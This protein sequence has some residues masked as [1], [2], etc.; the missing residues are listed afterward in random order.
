MSNLQTGSSLVFIRVPRDPSFHSIKAVSGPPI[1]ESLWSRLYFYSRC[2]QDWHIRFAGI[3]VQH[4]N[5]TTVNSLRLLSTLLNQ[6]KL[7]HGPFGQGNMHSTIDF[8]PRP[9]RKQMYHYIRKANIYKH[10][11]DASNRHTGRYITGHDCLQSYIKCNKWWQ[12]SQKSLVPLD[13]HTQQCEE[14]FSELTYFSNCNTRDF[15]TTIVKLYR[16]S[17]LSTIF[18]IWKKSYYAKFVLV[19]IT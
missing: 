10:T 12:R 7:V 6:I 18:G 16:G 15:S 17:S 4:I 9:G 8:Y 11:V 1:I 3:Q 5:I 2:K 13:K 14:I 19:G